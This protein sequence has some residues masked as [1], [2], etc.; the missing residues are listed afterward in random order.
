MKT[1]EMI[2]LIKRLSLAFGPSGMEDEV[3]ELILAE[4]KEF[5]DCTTV[6]ALGNITVKI[7]CKKSDAPTLMLCAHMDEVGMMVSHIEDCGV[8]RFAEI[9]G[10]SPSVL[11]GKRVTLYGH[12]RQKLDGVIASKAIHLQSAEERK[13]HVECDK[14]YIDIGA[15]TK[16]QA[17][18]LCSI[19]DCAVFSSDFEIFGDGGA[20]LKCK[21]LDDRVGCAILISIL[22]RLKEDAPDLN[23]NLAIAF[24]TREETGLSG[25]S[26][27]SYNACPD[28]AVILETTTIADLPSVE[29]KR[30]VAKIGGG[31]VLSLL[32]RASIYDR[33]FLSFVTNLKDSPSFQIK[34]YYAGGNDT[35][36]IQLSR[37]GCHAIALSVPTRYL[38]SASCV[39]SIDDALAVE[40]LAYR[41]ICD[42]D[43]SAIQK[44]K[45]DI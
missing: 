13:K 27:A 40:S 3:R 19:G 12:D 34:E 7:H 29:E 36:H 28:Y 21:A 43:E 30:R 33:G 31:G 35:R 38:H 5:S 17:E 15:N 22:R 6:D 1:S 39:I 23:C 32:D 14:L 41:I 9:G 16:A 37:D 18:E 2:E 8:L 44:A 45:G 24:T 42:F 20:M 4:C 10:I 25:A 26:V 11:S